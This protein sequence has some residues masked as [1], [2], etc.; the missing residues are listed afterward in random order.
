MIYLGY[1]LGGYLILVIV[2][3]YHFF[4]TMGDKNKK[5]N[6]IDIILITPLLPI[7]YIIGWLSKIG[8]RKK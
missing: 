2:G 8:R 1:I 6:L 3:M 4:K 5:D 7:A